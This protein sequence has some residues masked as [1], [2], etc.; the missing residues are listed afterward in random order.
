MGQHDARQSQDHAGRA[1]HSLKYRKYAEHY[2]ADFAYRFNRRFDLRGL[3]VRLIVDVVRRQP[4][5][6]KVVRASAAAGF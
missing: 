4:A 1:D 2:L 3:V 6:E 5:P